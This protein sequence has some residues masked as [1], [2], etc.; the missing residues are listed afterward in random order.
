M[1]PKGNRKQYSE[2]NLPGMD[3]GKVSRTDKQFTA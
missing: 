1:K 2:F 3:A